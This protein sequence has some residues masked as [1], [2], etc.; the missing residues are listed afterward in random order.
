MPAH[1][2]S[3]PQSHIVWDG[4][5]SETWRAS[6]ALSDTTTQIRIE[7][8]DGLSRMI[9]QQWEVYATSIERANSFVICNWSTS[10]SSQDESSATTAGE[11]AVQDEVSNASSVLATGSVVL[12]ESDPVIATWSS[13][14][15]ERNRRKKYERLLWMPSDCQWKSSLLCFLNVFWCLVERVEN[16]KRQTSC[17]FSAWS[18]GMSPEKSLL[19]AA[20]LQ[21]LIRKAVFCHKIL[22]SSALSRNMIRYTKRVSETVKENWVVKFGYTQTDWTIDRGRENKC[23]S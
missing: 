15:A 11:R 10:Q 22:C 18:S 21:S 4:L 7:R 3:Y 1:H 6:N 8:K 17:R 9:N 2:I 14:V 16:D 5:R 23:K 13:I 19:T 12:K 20:V